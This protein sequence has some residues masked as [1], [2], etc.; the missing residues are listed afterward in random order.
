MIQR[1]K[2]GEDVYDLIIRD[3]ELVRPGRDPIRGSVGI[4]GEKIRRIWIDEPINAES[5]DVIEGAGLCLLPGL[6]DTHVQTYHRSAERGVSPETR[7]AALGGVTTSLMMFRRMEPYGGMLA[8]N[9]ER[10]ESLAH[11]DF[12]YHVALTIP[13]HLVELPKIIANHG[14]KSFKMYMAYRGKDGAALGF[15]GADDGL[16][17]SAMKTLASYEDTKLLVHAEN[18]ELSEHLARELQNAGRDDLEAWT[19]SRPDFVEADAIGRCGL[20]STVTG[21]NVYI[22][23]VSSAMGLEMIRYWRSRGASLTAETCPHYLT[24]TAESSLGPLAKILPPLRYPR[25]R[26]ALWKALQDGTIDTFGSDHAVVMK[27]QKVDQNIWTSHPGFPGTGLLLSVLLS[28]GFHKGRLSL[29]QIAN[30]TAGNPARVFRLPGK[31][32]IDEGADADL[33]LV[34]L[35]LE[36]IVDG[37]KLG[38]DADWSLY[39]GCSLKGWPVMTISRGTIV[40]KGE[41]FVGREGHGRFIRR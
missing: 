2:E 23:H 11:I 22:A 40:V 9:I 27:A 6:I 39:D 18:F 29:G 7:S 28:E 3:A 38:S 16:L 20:L 33:V 5:R 8:S 31:G 21:C 37:A 14:V 35:D 24:H 1:P 13:E 34:N 15:Q 41:T 26:E 10:D 25:D 17:F 12:A 19:E 36:R 32:A 30:I 4:V